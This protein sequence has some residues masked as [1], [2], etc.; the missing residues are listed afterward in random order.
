MRERIWTDR[1]EPTLVAANTGAPAPNPATQQEHPMHARRT[2]VLGLALALAAAS[3]AL[4]APSKK[5]APSKPLVLTDQA[6]DANGI[7]SQ[8]GVV[9]APVPSQ[10]GQGQRTAADILSV[11]LGRLDDKKKVT[12]LT[13]TFVLSAAPDQG[14]IYRAQMTAPGCDTFWLAYHVPVGGPISASM[15]E[16][17]TTGTAVASAVTATVKD[18]TVTIVVPLA[19]LPKKITLGTVL[20]G[21]FGETKGH[22]HTGVQNP[23]VPTIDQTDT[24][25]ATY[26][27]GG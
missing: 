3:P 10:A 15:R 8:S 26:K 9:P 23:T 16:S 17:C 11:S 13:A 24:A 4:A 6:G 27:V 18:K 20:S 1:Q 25:T 7:N 21:L 22:A 12:A 19:S 2:A 5:L 14:T